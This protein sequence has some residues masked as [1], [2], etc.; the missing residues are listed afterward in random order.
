MQCPKCPFVTEYKHHL[1]YH[2]RNHFGS[3][4]FKCSKC[5]Y[6]CVNKSMLNSHMKSHTNVYQ[7]RCADCTYATKYCHSLKLHLR[8][9]NHKPAT[10]LNSDGSLPIDDPKSQTEMMIKAR[11]PPGK[12]GGPRAL[13]RLDMEPPMMAPQENGAIGRLP[14][15]GAVIPPMYWPVLNNGM[16]HN[17]PPP[18]IP[19]TNMLSM[20]TQHDRI[21]SMARFAGMDQQQMPSNSA[22]KCKLCC[23]DAEDREGLNKHMLKVHAAE[24]QDLFSAFGISSESLVD[25]VRHNYASETEGHGQSQGQGQATRASP[26]SWPRSEQGPAQPASRDEQRPGGAALDLSKPKDADTPPQTMVTT[27]YSLKR[28]LLEQVSRTQNEE[29]TPTVTP[30][31]VATPPRKRSRKGK[32]FKLDTNLMKMQEDGFTSPS[33]MENDDYERNDEFGYVSE[34]E[35]RADD[36]AAQKVPDFGEIHENLN[37]LNQHAASSYNDRY[38]AFTDEEKSP[39]QRLNALTNSIEPNYLNTKQDTNTFAKESTMSSGGSP[40]LIKSER[41]EYKEYKP[42]SP[43]YTKSESPY[44]TPESPY[45]PES[46][47]QAQ[48]GIQS[49]D[50]LSNGRRSISP[51]MMGATALPNGHNISMKGDSFECQ[52]CEIAFKDCVLYT[53]HMGYHGYKDAFHCNSCGYHAKDKVD[54]FLHI[55]RIAHV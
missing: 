33:G 10:I 52:Y 53:M 28:R 12:T 25:D 21:Q 15:N 4:P 16:H 9:Y 39:F 49:D 7:Y 30:Q 17:L 44:K 35:A 48:N 27:P 40:Y 20:T 18:L 51:E 54:F 3:K 43:A 24:N 2:L 23:F 41:P 46:P 55:A 8:K 38:A 42:E 45:K 14:M 50:S 29:A 6:S 11:C 1:E 34:N 13:K 19:V 26:Q 36:D 5:N 32:A 31:E 47:R 22:Y 37:R